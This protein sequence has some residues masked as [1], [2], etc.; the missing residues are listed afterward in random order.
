MA[1]S[2]RSE[3]L[4][5]RA[6]RGPEDHPAMN[7]VGNAVRAAN[8]DA[9][10]LSDADM[11]NYYRHLEHADLPRDCVLVE[12]DG[13]LVAYCRAS[14]QPMADGTGQVQTIANIHPGRRE[15][16]IE[17]R[18]L[19][20]VVRRAAELI[21][22]RGT[23]VESRL[24]VFAG[25]RDGRLRERL[26]ARGFTLVRRHAQ[27]VRASLSDIPD[28]PLPDPFE[29]RPIDPA[30]TAMH[31]RIFDA[32]ARAFADS[33]GQEA[34]SEAQWEAFIGAPSFDPALWRVAFDGEAIAGQILN[35]IDERPEDG[36][37]V[38]MTEAISVQPEYR[39]R[40]LARALLVTSLRAVRDAGATSAALGVDTHNPNE[41]LTLYESLGYRI[42]S[43]AFEYALG[44]FA[45]GSTPAVVDGSLR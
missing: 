17:D 43:E 16:G 35:F 26:A 23:E 24:V 18:L 27:L 4:V 2:D 39:R 19:D 7:R 8:G 3:H 34:T 29:I 40:G 11:D 9:E 5:L 33:Y 41:A 36:S 37:R 30:D 10:L 15:A 45:P 13:D 32:D 1:T 38:G 6:Y 12:L 20:H 44:P 21:A 25:G 14:W 42:V 31:R 28:L 22:A